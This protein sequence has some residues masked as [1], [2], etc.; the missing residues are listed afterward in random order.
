MNQEK[1][2]VVNGVFQKA[3]PKSH[4][5]RT[6][7]KEVLNQEIKRFLRQRIRETSAEIAARWME[8]MKAEK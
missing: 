4:P 5:G 3:N 7:P 8:E 2:P 1:L 6:Y